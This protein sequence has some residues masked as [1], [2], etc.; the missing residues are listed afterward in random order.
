[1]KITEESPTRLA[2]R[3]GT[4]FL[5]DCRCSFDRAT[6]RAVIRRRF[7]GFPRKTVDVALTDIA[8][9]R[10]ATQS[11]PDNSDVR[12]PEFVLKSG[13]CIALTLTMT[14]DRIVKMV[15]SFLGLQPPLGAAA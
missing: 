1:M 9:V 15:N 4:P 11:G 5:G 14:P 7:F 12:Y 3:S 2:F 6:G 13:T 10:V 8:S